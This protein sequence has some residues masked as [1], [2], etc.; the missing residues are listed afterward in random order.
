MKRMIFAILIIAT[1][2][3]VSGCAQ[4]RDVPEEEMDD[5]V[6]EDTT[7]VSEDIDENG[8]ENVAD[9]LAET[10]PEGEDTSNGSDNTTSISQED[11]DRLKEELEGLEFEDMGGLSEE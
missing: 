7:A 8:V 9:G 11:L 3:L 5:V 1:M 10:I 6:V 4:N 2:L